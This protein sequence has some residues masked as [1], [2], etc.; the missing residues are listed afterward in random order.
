MYWLIFEGLHKIGVKVGWGGERMTNPQNYRCK[1]PPF[2]FLIK[3][4]KLVPTSRGS[5]SSAIWI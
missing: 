4:G 3:D 5:P 2:G 1:N